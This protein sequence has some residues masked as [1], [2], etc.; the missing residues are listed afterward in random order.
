MEASA[1][2]QLDIPKYLNFPECVFKSVD[3]LPWM[4]IEPQPDENVDVET[5]AK[6]TSVEGEHKLKRLLRRK[7]HWQRIRT[8]FAEGQ[9][10]G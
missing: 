8:T 9:Y 10:D 5:L 3:L 7:N 1:S 2:P 6:D 4:R